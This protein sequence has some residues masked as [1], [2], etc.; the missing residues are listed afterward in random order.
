MSQTAAKE[1][2]DGPGEIPLQY[3]PSRLFSS[4]LPATSIFVFPPRNC[5]RRFDPVVEKFEFNICCK[6]TKKD[7]PRIAWIVRSL[8]HT[9]SCKISA[10]IRE[11]RGSNALTPAATGWIKFA[12]FPFFLKLKF[13][14][15]KVETAL[16]EHT[17]YISRYRLNESSSVL[18][19]SI[20][21]STFVMRMLDQ[22]RALAGSRRHLAEY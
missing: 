14:A 21:T 19:T 12:V 9:R 1:R 18:E 4:G 2:R 7:K 3:F 22:S 10:R 8:I 20:F 13:N 5:N 11:A 15:T 17:G 6:R 16:D